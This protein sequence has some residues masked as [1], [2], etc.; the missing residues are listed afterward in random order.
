MTRSPIPSTA[1]V[2]IIGNEILTGKVRDRN[3]AYLATELFELG[4]RLRRVVVCPDEVEI[5]ARD[6]SELRASHDVVFTSGGVGPTHDDVTMEAVARAL[7]REL[8]RAPE[9]EQLIRGHF[10]S[11]VTESHLRM[12]DVP[13]GS[14]LIRSGEMPW[15]TVAVEQVYVFPGVPEILQVKFPLLRERLRSD[16][17]FVS[18]AVYVRCDEF[19]L[20]VMLTEV[21][22][23]NPEVSIGSYLAWG[24][25]D[26]RVKLTL[27][28]V[29][30]DTVGKALAS[31]LS[32]LSKDDVVSTE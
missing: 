7:G 22:R 21:A 20:A 24:Q 3:I 1:A 4:V 2:L 5:I 26:H 16:T 14:T 23:E 15:P 9:L 28:G 31:L 17:R 32:R 27:D 10:G 6:V 30:A 25:P 8:R 19:A 11:A 12:A 29:D 18:R 13:E